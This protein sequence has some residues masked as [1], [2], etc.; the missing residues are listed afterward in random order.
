[1]YAKETD[2]H[3]FDYIKQPGHE[4]QLQDM[5]NHMDMK[6]LGQKWF[7]SSNLNIAEL[8]DHP[9]DPESVL[10]IDIGGSSGHDII[11][12]HK[13]FPNLPGR[14]VLQDLPSTIDVIP[15]GTLPKGIEPQGYDF[16]TPQPVKEAKVYYLHH[17]L[18]DW[19]DE[20]CRKILANIVPVMKK[21]YSKILLNEVVI[22]DK[23]AE[24]FATSLDM[25]MLLTHSA[26]E[27]TETQ[28]RELVESAGLRISRILDADAVP[29]KIIEVELA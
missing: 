25:L 6:T 4:E 11:D 5:A 13:A 1:M 17:V 18:H 3:Y 24:W 15:R 20:A 28:W 21:G 22:K 9:T 19:P 10:M 12:F 7:Q 2:L 29:E 27:R 16:F 23:G 26:H 14:L 8:F